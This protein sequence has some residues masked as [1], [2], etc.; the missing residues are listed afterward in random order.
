MQEL[1]FHE[2]RDDMNSIRQ[3]I[4]RPGKTI[5]GILLIL[6]ACTLLCV[7]IG[8]YFAAIQMQRQVEGEY[9]TIALP[10]N[11]FKRQEILDE[12]GESVGISYLDSQPHEVQTFLSGLP[13][14]FPEMVKS[15][16]SPGFLSGYCP[17]MNPINY[18][19][20]GF[21]AKGDG[22]TQIDTVPYTCA[23]FVI[24]VNQI[25]D[26]VEAEDAQRYGMRAA[27]EGTV[28]E[29]YMLQDGYAD[30]TGRTIYLQVGVESEEAF[31]ALNLQVGEAYLVYGTDYTDLDWLLRCEIA[32]GKQEVYDTISWSNI[33]PLTEEEKKILNE[34]NAVNGVESEIVALY[35]VHMD[36]VKYGMYL[37]ERH[38]T[39]IDSCSMTVCSNLGL[40][41]GQLGQEEIQVYLED[42]VYNIPTEEY[43][44][45]YGRPGIVH[46]D[47]DVEEFWN[48]TED[49][50]WKSARDTVQINNHAFPVVATGNLRS[51]AQFG[52]QDALLSGGR[53][54]SAEEYEQGSAVCVIS[55]S[56]AAQN[57][58]S[59]G[60][61][62]PLQYYEADR[63]LPNQ[64]YLKTGNPS[65]FF[66]SPDR[67][68][69][70]EERAYEI[71][72]L[73]RQKE[74]WSGD[75]Y[76][77]T[78]NTIFVPKNSAQGKMETSDSGIFCTFVLENGMI[79]RME[80]EVAAAGFEG[81]L[82]YYD[83]GF[84]DIQASL[85]DYF[86]VSRTILLIGT[87]SWVGLAAVFV[88]LFPG[89][90]RREA[91]RMWTLGTPRGWIVRHIVSGS[92]GILVPGLILGGLV[93]LGVMG[94][95]LEQLG[96]HAGLPLEPVKSLGQILLPVFVQFLI[97]TVLVLL[98][99]RALVRSLEKK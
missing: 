7:S 62:I 19:A 61:F 23:M 57:G 83:Q 56:L 41:Q 45:R 65:P 11:R 40:L 12:Q 88:F 95:V 76:A 99:G 87:L 14:Q 69:C 98:A 93:S 4:R 58:L 13:E 64:T 51:I 28:E 66:Y 90:Q 31:R 29:V 85:S 15:V 37:T 8:Q 18:E 32:N 42:G 25:S 82:T 50:R 77:F 79:G 59:V 74:A 16:E 78:P 63:M 36:G 39:R 60:D 2:K 38:L 84:S 92:I 34:N 68:F 52:T 22:L 55:E 26:L 72:G 9:T 35:Q 46:L 54:F 49:F 91:E 47:G 27:V 17:A 21:Q 48:T 24:T 5:L 96:T 20:V 53:M 80:Q 43:E 6:L 97:L 67:G 94:K 89:H 30:P 10:T 44:E 1:E 81:L 70:S 33:T 3:L 71:V 73:Y 86:S 75:A